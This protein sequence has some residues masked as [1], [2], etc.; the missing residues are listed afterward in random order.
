MKQTQKKLPKRQAKQ[1]CH[2]NC[3]IWLESASTHKQSLVKYQVQ[4]LGQCILKSPWVMIATPMLTKARV[5]INIQERIKSLV[6]VSALGIVMWLTIIGPI[7][8]VIAQLKLK[9]LSYSSA[10]IRFCPRKTLIRLHLKEVR[11]STQICRV[12]AFKTSYS[13]WVKADAIFLVKMVTRMEQ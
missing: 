7:Q 13:P 1:N 12:S 4:L 11:H 8:S 5:C 3:T 6:L 9:E 10:W 2:H